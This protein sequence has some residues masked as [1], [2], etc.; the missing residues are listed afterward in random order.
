VVVSEGRNRLVRRLW[1]AGGCRVSRLIRIRYG[2]I[3]LDRSLRAGKSR[4][5]KPGELAGLY[6]AVGMTPPEK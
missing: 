5:L 2:S 4:F 6:E 3:R 1:E